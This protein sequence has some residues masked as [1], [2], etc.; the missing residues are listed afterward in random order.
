MNAT[1]AAPS[2]LSEVQFHLW[3]SAITADDED[4]RWVT[5]QIAPDPKMRVLDVGGGNGQFASILAE[6]CRC[7][8]DV[9]DPS[10]VAAEHFTKSPRCRLITGDFN[11]WAGEPGRRYDLIV[12]R[13]VLHHLIDRDDSETTRIQLAALT[14]AA[15]LL[16]DQGRIYIL[17]NIYEPYVGEDVS[18]RLIYEATKLKR[19][20]DVF[21]RLGANTAGEG[22]RFH[23]MAAWRRLLATAGL[24]VET[25]YFDRAWAQPFKL[26]Q[27]LPFLC[28]RRYQWLALARPR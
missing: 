2:P 27:R 26:W 14:K 21:R 18:A 3:S 13:V 11:T 1:D 9:I 28:A 7:D 4:V 5:A 25:E 8:V 23:S 17:E 6:W 10:R 15:A 16:S 12:F 19:T 24:S 22:V 20:A